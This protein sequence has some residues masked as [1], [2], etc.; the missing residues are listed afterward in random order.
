MKKIFAVRGMHCASC[1]LNIEKSVKKIG[2]VSSCSVNLMAEKMY[3][4]HDDS[5]S[6]EEIK[7][8]VSRVGD[9]SA[10]LHSGAREENM[11]EI[12]NF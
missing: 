4:E 6:D 11:G 12:P 5:V 1:A 7:K 8:A 3:I 2:G 9:Y 10:N